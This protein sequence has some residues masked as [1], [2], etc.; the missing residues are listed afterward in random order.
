MNLIESFKQKL[1]KICKLGFCASVFVL[2]SFSFNASLN[3]N[4]HDSQYTDALELGIYLES[5]FWTSVQDQNVKEFSNS[6]AHIFQGLNISGVYTREQQIEGLTGATL[7]NFTFNNPIATRLHDVLVF[8]YD[9]VAIGSDLTS[10]PS[11]TVW[12]KHAHC[13]KI[14]SHSYV[15]FID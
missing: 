2:S 5:K 3:A 8:S 13:W 4:S 6:L 10:G 15:P 1:Y 9:F 14:V 12:K 7:A 11:I